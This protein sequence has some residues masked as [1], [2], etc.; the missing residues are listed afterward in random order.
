IDEEEAWESARTEA[1]APLRQAGETA[2]RAF[3]ALPDPANDPAPEGDAK[4]R[5]SANG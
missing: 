1:F 5:K 4:T 2:R 3:F